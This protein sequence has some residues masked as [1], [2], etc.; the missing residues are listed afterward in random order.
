MCKISDLRLSN[1]IENKKWTEMTAKHVKKTFVE[2]NE[3]KIHPDIKAKIE[4]HLKDCKECQNYYL[5]MENIF[6]GAKQEFL[7]RL[8]RDHYLPTKIKALAQNKDTISAKGLPKWIPSTKQISFGLLL[9]IGILVGVYLGEWISPTSNNGD[10]E[11]IN[12]YSSMFNNE[13][14]WTSL[15]KMFDEN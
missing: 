11:L 1:I 12:S 7:P 8:E 9:A 5:F 14:S 13:N 15:E 2:W 10:T 3:E 6:K 4:N